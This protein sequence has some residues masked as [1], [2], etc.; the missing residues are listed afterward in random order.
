MDEGL[1]RNQRVTPGVSRRDISW[2]ADRQRVLRGISA[3]PAWADALVLVALA[4]YLI[5][6]IA[7]AAPSRSEA[8]Q[9]SLTRDAGVLITDPGTLLPGGSGSAAEEATRLGYGSLTRFLAA[10]GW[11]LTAGRNG[12][13]PLD[14]AAAGQPATGPVELGAVPQRSVVAARIGPVMVAVLSLIMLFL[15]ARRLL[16]RPA[17][18]VAVLAFALQPAVLETGRQVSDSGVTVVLGLAAVFVAAGIGA[19]LSGGAA[20]SLTAWTGRARW[21]GLCL[22]AGLSAAPFVAGALVFCLAGV[23]TGQ[24]RRQRALMAGATVDSPG[25]GRVV[26]WLLVSVLGT[27]IVWVVM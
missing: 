5:M 6:G 21:A 27:L 14:L 18:T 17:A 23:V 7:V 8:V 2:R 24:T 10:P 4:G 15:L 3:L 12:V 11:Y 26:A 1:S 13:R 20:P 16:G 19:Q 9:I 25:L 22:A